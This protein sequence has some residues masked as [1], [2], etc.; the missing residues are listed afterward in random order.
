MIDT[1]STCNKAFVLAHNTSIASNLA[2]EKFVNLLKTCE[3]NLT[4]ASQLPSAASSRQYQFVFVD[5][6][7][8][9]STHYSLTDIAKLAN[10]TNIVLF[11]CSS[12]CGD[13]KHPLFSGIKGI[14][15]Q[16]DRPDIILKGIQCL[17]KGESWFK[18]STMS[19]ALSELL[20]SSIKS[21][22]T[23]TETDQI[24]ID[25]D[26]LTKR[27]KTIVKLVSAGAQNKEI[28]AHLHISPNTVKTHIYSIFRKTNSRNRIELITWSQKLSQPLS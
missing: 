15:Y 17:S 16:Q 11:N 3:F 4:I 14:F 21:L 27:E 23:S 24:E 26:L 10:G 5:Y 18:R 9:S 22:K 8:Q 28:A 1:S 13:E 2:L 19:A 12:Q 7:S 20:S 25:S 6:A